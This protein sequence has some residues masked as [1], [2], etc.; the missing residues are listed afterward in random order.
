M[1]KKQ[2]DCA[3]CGAPV[4]IIGRTLCC[5]CTARE[6]VRAAQAVCPQC[7]LS[8][9]LQTESGLCVSCSRRCTRCGGPLRF[10]H[11]TLCKHCRRA[12]QLEQR[13]A[14]RQPCRRCGRLGYLRED[15]GWCGSC[16]RPGPPRKPPRVCR[17]CGKLTDHIASGM[18]SACWQRHPDRPFIRMNHLAAR[19]VDPPLWLEEFVA[20]LAARHCASRCC[21]L[22]T[23]LGRLLADEHSGHPQVVLERSRQS[24]RSMGTLARGLE[25]FFTE[26]R[27]ALP[28]DQ[29]DRLAAGRRQRRVDAVPLRLRPAVD[30]YA[31][32]LSR[33]RERARR[34][35]TKP[36]SDS[37][38]ESALA[39][40]RD[41]AL[42]LATQRGKQDWALVEVS[43]VEAF[44]A[45][46]PG[47]RARHLSVLRQFFA[48]ARRD[49]I[50]L[51]DPSRGVAAR[52]G[53]NFSGRTITLDDQRALFRRWSTDPSVHPHEALLGLLAL[54]HGAASRE[55]RLLRI[56]DIDQAV[57]SARLGDRPQ[58]VPLDP[59]SWA[60]LERCLA[61]REQ[62]RTDNPHVVVTRGTKA[63]RSPASS[64]Y[65]SHVLDP[66]GVATHRLRVTRLADLV[67]TMDPKLVAAAFGMKPEGVLIYLADHVDAGRLAPTRATSAV[68]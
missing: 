25:E 54:L 56:D 21:Q 65:F 62:L 39:A 13:Q 28:T 63:L 60:A 46:Q 58:P 22:I 34:A 57:R 49:R 16:S 52:R 43:D 59:V 40:M 38:V 11:S 10:K 36:R 48:V 1:G 27:L 8:R 9:A 4:G 31:Q 44:L 47:M 6:K 26:H 55:L 50:V 19:L 3:E 37:T 24:G 68:T 23:T 42:F 18:C 51:V 66:A 17:E 41:F 2:C 67:N 5:R 64:A 12:D 35:G 29:A 53:R 15:T 7:G 33:G 32:S 45:A 61:H 30:R 14:T 20:Y